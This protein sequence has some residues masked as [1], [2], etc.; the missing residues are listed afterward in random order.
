MTD[1]ST[2]RNLRI[3]NAPEVTKHYVALDYLSTCERLLFETYIPQGSAILDLGVGGGRTTSYLALRAARYVGIDNALAMVAACRT[4][5][6][7]LEFRVM[8]AADLSEFSDGSFDA[9]VFAF[10]GIDFVLPE[11]ARRQCFDHIQR[12][13]KPGGRLIFSSHNARAIFARP[14]WNRERL[15]GIAIRLSA[16]SEFLGSLIFGA[17]S[18]V[19]AVVAVVQA[20]G[21]SLMRV[22]RF[23]PR[24]MF[25]RGEGERLDSAH[26]G[27]YTHY[28]TPRRAIAE[29]SAT[30]LR[31][32]RVVGNEYP[33]ASHP[34]KTD[35][36]YYVFVKPVRNDWNPCDS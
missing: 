25:W 33:H 35:W 26:G 30:M 11:S 14:S 32:E 23:V 8:D 22:S 6:P 34:L 21:V 17:L 13:L 2:K 10:N 12:V 19:R 18:A 36:Y 15:R 24:R 1:D 5:Y 7:G 20:F 29:V 9:V 4:K 31:C 28:C 3:Y 27:L 16:A